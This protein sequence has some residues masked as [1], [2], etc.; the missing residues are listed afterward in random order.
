MNLQG[1]WCPPSPQADYT[2]STVRPHPSGHVQAPRLL[3]LP[4]LPLKPGPR[5]ACGGWV[6]TVWTL[7]ARRPQ[8][9]P[10]TPLGAQTM[11]SLPA[12]RETRV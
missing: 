7:Q 10:G 9:L 2:G 5:A 12:M 1:C 6:P 8:P 11:R 3:S 4:R